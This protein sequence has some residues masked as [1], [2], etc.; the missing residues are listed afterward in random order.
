[1]HNSDLIWLLLCGFLVALMQAGFTCLESGLVRA[2]NSINVAIK[3]IVDFCISCILFSMFGFG[4]MFGASE[5]GI[6]GTS[7]FLLLDDISPSLMGFFFFQMVFCGTATTIVSGAVAERM[8]F[9]GYLFVAVTIS[10]VIYPITGHWA[11]N[12]VDSGTVQGWLGARGFIDFAG[13]TVVHSVAGWVALAAVLVI[14]PRIGRFTKD[15]TNPIEGNNLPIATLGV[16]I[17]WFGWFGFNGGSLFQLT[18]QIPTIVT[19][20]ALS[21]AAGGIAA[22][23]TSWY[24]QRKPIVNRIINGVIAGLVSITASCHL[25][26]PSM[27]IVVGAVGGFICVVGMSF[28]ERM[29]LD[30]AIGAIPTHL[31][32]GIWGTLAVSFVDADILRTHLSHWEQFK[33]QVFGAFAIGL[34]AFTVSFSLFKLV[35]VWF[36]LRVTAEE[37]RIGLNMS[38]HGASSSIHDLI[39]QMD[40]QARTGKF[41]QPVVIEPET[42]AHKIGHFYN[43]VLDTI[44]IECQQREHITTDLGN[45]LIAVMKKNNELDKLRTRADN[46]NKSKSLFV[47]NMSHE[48]RTPL[49]AIIGYSELIKE[50]DEINQIASDADKISSAGRHLLT[51][52]ND[53][54]DISKLESGNIDVYNEEFSVL[55]LLHDV[56]ELSDPLI[57]K[58]NNNFNYHCADD[59][60]QITS[61]KTKIKQI[62]LNLIGNA[63]KFTRNGIITLKVS[64]LITNK[65]NWIIFE[66]SDTGIGMSTVQQEKVFEA[67]A[68][69]DLSTTKDYGGTGLGLAISKRFCV[70]MGGYINI[71]SEIDKGSVFTVK[72]PM[73]ADV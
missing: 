61:D 13:S 35:N 2:K 50:E 10:G 14:G 16:F 1:M 3:N 33:T 21:G 6:F 45:M 58:N 15:K 40:Y 49:N 18:D 69:A 22:M 39:S 64:K 20:T 55:D 59:I 24:I 25:M 72:L 38:E 44:A 73:Q 29:K 67:Y 63:G 26:A 53:I 27:S 47:A 8:R 19:N 12:G 57:N 65:E 42:E 4:L 28:L 46:E 52:I 71:Q 37:E 32:A 7:H 66:V 60:R 5:A 51:L 30:D 17:L 34:Y 43:K 31:F 23:F 70:L 11:W 62:L 68:Q 56:I 36:R 9:S 48:L 41:H 54:L